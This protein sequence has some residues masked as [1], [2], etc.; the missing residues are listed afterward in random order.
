M[1]IV[2]IAL[3]ASAL[4]VPESQSPSPRR[5]DPVGQLAMVVLLASCI[6]AIIE[7]PHAGWLS[8][9]T[10]S[11]FGIGA[12]SLI[13]LLIYEPRRTDPLIE[14]RFFRSVPFCGATLVAISAFAAFAGF[15]FLN[16]LYLQMVRG[17]SPM[18][19]GLCTLPLGLAV[20]VFS[21]ISG[22][23]VGGYGPRRTPKLAARYAAEFNMPFPQPA[24]YREQAMRVADACTAIGRDPEDLIFSVSLTV[25]CGESDEDLGLRA[26]RIGRSVDDLREHACAGRPSDVVNRIAD[27]VDAGAQRVYLQLLDL[28][29]LDH[30]HLLSERVLAVLP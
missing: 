4:F 8:S 21:P 9:Q 11:L 20:L 25:C 19:A 14:L 16:T 17:L 29:D 30:L 22:R 27:F 6:Y 7:A 26:G 18:Q 28:D 10:L 24:A 3:L 1:P 12:V 13:V 23:V 2:I 15:L 5:I